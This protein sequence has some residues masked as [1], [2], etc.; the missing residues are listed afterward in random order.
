MGL[1]RG[2]TLTIFRHMSRFGIGDDSV[3][4]SGGLSGSRKGVDHGRSGDGG[5]GK[6]LS[7]IG[8]NVSRFCKML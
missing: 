7:G 1:A 2:S 3:S 4:Y 6:K 8:G 5:G